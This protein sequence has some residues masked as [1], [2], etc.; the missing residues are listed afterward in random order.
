[1]EKFLQLRHLGSCLGHYQVF[2]PYY[3]FLPIKVLSGLDD[4]ARRQPEKFQECKL[5]KVNSD[6][7]E[8][9]IIIPEGLLLW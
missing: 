9:G 1:M 2:S 5:T 6:Q 4:R 7:K 8:K 3:R